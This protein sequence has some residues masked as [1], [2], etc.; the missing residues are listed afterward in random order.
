MGYRGGDP[1]DLQALEQLL[2]R[3]AR[4]ADDLPEVAELELNPVVASAVGLRVL[5][6]SARV[7]SPTARPDEGARRLL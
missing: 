3:V 1:V 4:L 5:G 7:A 6:A 2:L